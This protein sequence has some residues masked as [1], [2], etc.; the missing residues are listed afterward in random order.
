[1]WLLDKP[2]V[3]FTYDLDSIYK[4][5]GVVLSF[6]S[7]YVYGESSKKNINQLIKKLN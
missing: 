5:K 1:M 3:Y 4:K 6:F 2:I 7:D